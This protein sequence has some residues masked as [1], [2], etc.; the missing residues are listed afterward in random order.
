MTTIDDQASAREQQF[1]EYAMIVRRPE[2][3]PAT[4]QCLNC[5]EVL[6][7]TERW[8]DADCRR[9]WEARQ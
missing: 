6:C 1:T 5:G 7:G 9:D 8:C 2:G 4:G 3:P